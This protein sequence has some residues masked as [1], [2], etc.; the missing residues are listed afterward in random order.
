MT[1]L[2]LLFFIANL[3][4]GQVVINEYSASNLHSFKDNYDKT[5]DQLKMDQFYQVITHQLL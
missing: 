1:L 3:T 5:E 2:T 4:F